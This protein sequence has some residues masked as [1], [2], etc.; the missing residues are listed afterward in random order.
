MQGQT[1]CVEFRTVQNLRHKNA[2]LILYY[3]TGF[4]RQIC[5]LVDDTRHYDLNNENIFQ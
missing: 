3:R 4:K 1:K 2:F 5:L